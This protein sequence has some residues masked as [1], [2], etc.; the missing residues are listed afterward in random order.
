MAKTKKK[1]PED[2]RN[3]WLPKARISESE[4]NAIKSKAQKAK[5]SVSEYQRKMC[6]SGK[7]IVQTNT[8][9]IALISQLLSIGNN[10]NQL[11]KSFHIRGL[12]IQDQTRLQDGL[13]LL[14]DVLYGLKNDR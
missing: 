10:L 13:D 12:A 1:Q 11:T 8:T 6:L 3:L 9:D 14:T 7:V 2:A 4:L 5:L